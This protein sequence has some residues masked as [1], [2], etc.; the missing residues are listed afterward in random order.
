MHIWHHEKELR[1]KSGV[2]FG[3]AL[4]VWDY[5]FTTAYNPQDIDG[6]D[7]ELSFKGY[8]KYPKGFLIQQIQPFVELF[9]KE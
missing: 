7:L 5:F 3:A 6:K 4:S 2:N 8:E 1:G 9:K